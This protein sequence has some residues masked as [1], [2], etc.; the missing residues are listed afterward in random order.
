M[1]LS[2]EFFVIIEESN[3]SWENLC[4]I[5]TPCFTKTIHDILFFIQLFNSFLLSNIVK[6]NNTIWNSLGFDNFNPSNFS[7]AITMGSTAS[8]SINSGNIYNSQSVSWNNTT[9]IK[10]ETILS[11]SFSFIHIRFSDSVTIVN[12]SISLVFNSFFF[13]F[14]QT[15]VMCDI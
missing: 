7:S 6:S 2:W 9:L 10:F 13:I 11:L 8:F 1:S 12:C 5:N 4:L 15:L 14:C 3:S